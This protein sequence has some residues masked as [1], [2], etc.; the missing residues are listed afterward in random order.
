MSRS[1]EYQG[2]EKV[3]FRC[4][5]VDQKGIAQQTLCKTY[6]KQNQSAV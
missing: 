4:I 1:L 5:Y 3:S 6:Y 2:H